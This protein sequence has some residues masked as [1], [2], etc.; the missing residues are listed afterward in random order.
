MADPIPFPPSS[1]LLPEISSFWGTSIAISSFGT[2]EVLPTPA[3]R[4]YSIKSS[5]LTSSPSMTLTQPP[6]SI[7]P[8]AVAPLLTSPLLPL[9]LLFLDPG[10]CYRTW[11]L[12]IYQFFYLSFSLRSFAPTSV[13]LPSIPKKLSGMALTPTLTFTVLQQR[14]TRLFLFPLLLLYLP[15]WH[16]MQPNLPFLSAASNALLKPGGLLRWKKR[17]VKDAR[18]SL[19]LTEVM[20]IDRLTSPLL[21][22]P[23]QSSPRPRLRHGSRL[24][25]LFYLGLTLNLYTLFFALSLA[26]LPRLLPLLTS[27]TALLPG[28]RL[29]SMPLT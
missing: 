2:Q 8:L 3:G 4:K 5:P 12:T 10:R 17:L 27:R 15:L 21:D 25:L 1:F 24:A 11:I 28:N 29:R 20:K 14:N 16:F 26:H 7:A 23:R 22:A 13:P 19:P 9:L 6:F 18:L